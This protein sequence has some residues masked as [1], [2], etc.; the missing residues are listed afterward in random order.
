MGGEGLE[1]VDEILV[2]IQ[3]HLP[4]DL[5]DERLDSNTVVEESFGRSNLNVDRR[6]S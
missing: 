5:S 3:F 2:E 1:D 4:P 6:Q